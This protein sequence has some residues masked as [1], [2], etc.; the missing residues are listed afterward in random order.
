[1]LDPRIYRTGLVAVLLA[2]IVFAFSLQGQQGSLGASLAPGAFN[3]QS[4]FTAMTTLANH[5]PHR[6]AGSANDSAIAS[7]VAQQLRTDAFSVS[8]DSFSAATPHGT[9]TLENV[10]GVRTGLA[11]GSIVVIAHRDA[12]RAPAKAELSGTGVLLDLATALSG[13]TLNHTIV[14]ASTSGSTGA[15]GA[16]QLMRS[17]PGPVDAV[18]VLGD[19]AGPTLR[20]PIVVPWSDG[21]QLAPPLLRNTVAGALATQAG[22]SAG[23]TSL[24]GDFVHLAFP[25]TVSEQ[26]AFNAGGIPAVTLSSSGELAPAG[27]EAPSSG[28]IDQFGRAALQTVSALD[29]APAIQGPSAYLQINGDTIPLWAVRLLVLALI[30]PVLFTTVDG[31]ARARR[32]GH[33]VRPWVVWV[34]AGAVPFILAAAIVW[35]AKLSG[36]L[37][38]APPGAVGPN[39]VPLGATGI[40]LLAVVL[41][42]VVLSIVLIRRSSR[43]PARHLASGNPG[44]VAGLLLV[45]CGLSLAI[46]VTNPFAAALLV[47]ALH[48]WMWALAPDLQMHPAVRLGLFVLG[49]VPP[50]LVI[51]YYMVALAF[52][53]VGF[54]WSL[55]LLLAGGHVGALVA[56]EWSVALGCTVSVFAIAGWSVRHLAAHDAPVTMRGPATY[57]GPGSLGGTESA[58]RR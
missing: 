17:L 32:R 50:L 21:S 5:F 56:L 24:S 35:V 44:A 40:A 14:L 8:T 36:L 6:Q 42:V 49:L 38:M 2:V 27:G 53:P 47:P 43:M 22:V 9:R 57:A 46:W 34:L 37:S 39:A 12:I 25:F 16:A 51:V 52:N 10:I 13:E 41:C 3:G 55:V 19:M 29:A 28:Q 20:Q 58:L 31:F 11:N 23:G 18:L 7:E 54:A 26:G 15:A 48:L 45:M 4:A 33:P 30:L 1:M